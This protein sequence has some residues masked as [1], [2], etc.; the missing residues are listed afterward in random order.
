MSRSF[1][2]FGVAL[3]VL[4]G[5]HDAGASMA[6]GKAEIL[7][8]R[9]GVPHIFAA[10][11]ES[12]FYGQGWAQM[13]AQANLLLQSVRRV[14]RPRRRILGTVARRTRSMGAAERRA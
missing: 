4:A 11:R 5:N 14:A 12:M 13:Q 3:L 7:W 6:A 10:D 8:D 1:T 2:M 9:Y